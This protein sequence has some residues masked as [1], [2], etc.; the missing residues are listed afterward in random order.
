MGMNTL[1]DLKRQREQLLAAQT[2]L[3]ETDS[4]VGHSNRLMNEMFA[5]MNINRVLSY[6]VVGLLVITILLVI[7]YKIFG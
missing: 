7:Y 3:H 2:R 4:H 5:R 6:A 1:N